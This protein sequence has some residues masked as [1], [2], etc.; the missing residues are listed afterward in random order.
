MRHLKVAPRA[1]PFTPDQ[2]EV[3]RDRFAFR[4]KQPKVDKFYE[5]ISKILDI[6][7]QSIH[8]KWEANKVS[9]LA[10]LATAARELPS[11]CAGR[12]NQAGPRLRSGTRSWAERARCWHSLERAS[13]RREPHETELRE[14]ECYHSG[15]LFA[16]TWKYLHSS[17]TMPPFLWL[18]DFFLFITS[19]NNLI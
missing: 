7:Q 14:L 5:L 11:W 13:E 6:I 12:R 1:R 16:C 10:A 4:V 3:T 2:D 15:G 9:S 18:W 19:L 17:V 8:D